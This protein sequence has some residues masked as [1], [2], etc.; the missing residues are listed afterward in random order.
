MYKE[1]QERKLRIQIENKM[2]E[3]QAAFRK[4][5]QT[6]DYISVVIK[7]IES[8]IE[9]GKSLYLIFIDLKPA[10]DTVNRNKM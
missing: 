3:K 8:A 1:I 9:H 7:V 6:Q 2:E 5:R 10:F 4:G